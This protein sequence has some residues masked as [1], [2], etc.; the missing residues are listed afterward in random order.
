MKFVAKNPKTGL[1]FSASAEDKQDFI[2]TLVKRAPHIAGW[3][4]D[5]IR[6]CVEEDMIE[7]AP[8]HI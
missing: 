4:P 3:Y 1:T 5:E 2:L 6:A 7:E 8:E